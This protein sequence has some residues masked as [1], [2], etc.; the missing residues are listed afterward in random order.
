MK[1]VREMSSKQNF[2]IGSTTNPKFHDETTN[3]AAFSSKN[4]DRVRLD[5]SGLRQANFNVGSSKVDY[6]TTN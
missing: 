3:S 5:M 1:N 4:T 6:T 2:S